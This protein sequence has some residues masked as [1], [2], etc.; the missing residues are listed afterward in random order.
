MLFRAARSDAAGVRWNT[1]G[2]EDELYPAD[3]ATSGNPE[4]SGARGL[5]DAVRR[6]RLPAARITQ[7]GQAAAFGGALPRTLRP[8]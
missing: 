2:P 7:L 4:R 3:A 6:R 1:P 8:R 5:P